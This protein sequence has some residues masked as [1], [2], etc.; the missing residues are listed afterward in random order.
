MKIRYLLDTNIVS[1]A[2]KGAS[3][4]ARMRLA[5][6]PRDEV[7]ISI[8]TAMELRFGLAKHPHATRARAVIDPFLATVQIANLPDDLPATYG[9]VRAGLERLGRPIGAL[10]TIIAAHAVALRCTLVTNNLREFRRVRGLRC[11]DWTRPER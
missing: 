1:L 7:A 9:S 11:E 6:A 2:L 5:A 4:V 3:P 8:I 10:D